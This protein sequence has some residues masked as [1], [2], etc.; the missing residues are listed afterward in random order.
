[1]GDSG[2][3][4]TGIASSNTRTG[5][6]VVDLHTTRLIKGILRITLLIR[7]HSGMVM[8]AAMPRLS[9][10]S[11]GFAKVLNQDQAQ[12]SAAIWFSIPA[13]AVSASPPLTGGSA[14]AMIGLLHS[15]DASA[16]C[17]MRFHLPSWSVS[18]SR[19]SIYCVF[20]P[21]AACDGRWFPVGRESQ[22]ECVGQT[23]REIVRAL[24]VL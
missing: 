2:G 19:P 16:P 7:K 15:L 9:S 12:G 4:Q 3:G 17:L 24:L 20:R 23:S 18:H 5:K 1:M 6:P 8:S 21:G 13:P 14:I 10:V 22:P 11:C